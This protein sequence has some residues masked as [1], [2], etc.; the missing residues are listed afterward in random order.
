MNENNSFAFLPW[1]D[2]Q[3]KANGLSYNRFLAKFGSLSNSLYT[4]YFNFRRQWQCIDL[5]PI[6]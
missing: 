4:L 5:M 2:K 3:R 6:V 1:M